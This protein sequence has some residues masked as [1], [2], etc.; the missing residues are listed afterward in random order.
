MLIKCYKKIKQN[1]LE[2]HKLGK[3]LSFKFYKLT[4]FSPR[5]TSVFAWNILKLFKSTQEF[6]I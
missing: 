3:T 4:F 1:T 6:C 2:Q 5:L